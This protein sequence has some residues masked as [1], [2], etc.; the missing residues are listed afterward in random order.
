M[1]GGEQHDGLVGTVAG[2]V[3]LGDDDAGENIGG[4]GGTGANA[5]ASSIK[6]SAAAIG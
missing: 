3:E 5:N 6:S 4:G 1:P 2:S